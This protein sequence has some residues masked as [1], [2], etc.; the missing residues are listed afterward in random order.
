MKPF[1]LADNWKSFPEAVRQNESGI[2]KQYVVKFHKKLKKHIII[3]TI[4][5]KAAICKG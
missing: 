3:Y 4:E 2:K 1:I 5:N